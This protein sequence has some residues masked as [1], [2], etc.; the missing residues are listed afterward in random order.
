M[1]RLT[2]FHRGNDPVQ[3]HL[4]IDRY[5]CAAICHVAENH[6]ARSICK[7]FEQLQSDLYTLNM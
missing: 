4:A 3:H 7:T 6:R 2:W 1:T 5:V